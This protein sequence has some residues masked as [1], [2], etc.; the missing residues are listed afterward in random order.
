[1]PSNQCCLPVAMRQATPSPAAHLVN[2]VNFA[3]IAAFQ[4]V[5]KQVD[6]G[7]HSAHRTGSPV[8]GPSRARNRS[9]MLTALFSSRSITKLQF[10]LEQRY[11]R[12]QS[13]M[14]CLCLH[15]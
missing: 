9:L 11:V 13:G 5:F 6:C 2:L 8:C 10:S 3:F 7:E 1:M 12:C 15:T 14:C 4:N